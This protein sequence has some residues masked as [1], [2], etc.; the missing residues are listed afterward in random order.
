MTFG[1]PVAALSRFESTLPH[2]NRTVYSD[3]SDNAKKALTLAVFAVLLPHRAAPSTRSP[4][5]LVFPIQVTRVRFAESMYNLAS[6]NI[7]YR[8]FLFLVLSCSP[9]P[10]SILHLSNG[11]P[12]VDKAFQ[13]VLHSYLKSR[14]KTG[15]SYFCYL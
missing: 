12:T 1:F 4:T 8:E 13:I 11:R 6:Q 2:A 14:K 7:S 15:K 10:L 3:V 9:T 5:F